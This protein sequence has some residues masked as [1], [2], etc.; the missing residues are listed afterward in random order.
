MNK[1]IVVYYSKT[2]NNKY[3]A[4]KAAD[5]LHCPAISLKPRFSPFPFLLLS[6]ATKLSFG[7]RSLKYNFDDYDSV[8]LCGPIWMGQFVAPLYDFVQKYKKNIRKLNFI[9][10]CGS[11]DAAKEDKFGYATVFPKIR[12]LLGEKCENCEALPIDLVLPDDK[13]GDDQAMMSARLS[14]A[15]FSGDIETRFVDFIQQ[16]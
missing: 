10:C 1:N 9:T 13:K 3:L 2:G 11:K 7:N 14:D 8:I 4:E 15:N 5:V 6:S 16:I 12:E